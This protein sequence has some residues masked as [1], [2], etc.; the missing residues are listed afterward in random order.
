MPRPDKLAVYL[1]ELLAP[2]GP[3]SARRMFG[4]VG[5]FHGATMFGLLAREE[6]FFKV[7]D[8]NR[9]DYEAAGEAPFS[10]PTK[11]GARTLNTYWRCP[12]ELLDDA[13]ELRDWARKAVAVALAAAKAKP[14]RPRKPRP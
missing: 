4:G 12:P 6:V 1:L 2:L 8:A 9:A 10:Y 14:N 13:D 3:V 5:L 7:G 11:D